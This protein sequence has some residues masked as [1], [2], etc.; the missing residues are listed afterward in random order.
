MCSRAAC[1]RFSVPLA[2]T[3]K[4]VCGSRRRPVVRRLRGRVD[5]E[6]DRAAVLGEQRVDAVGVADVELERAEA[7]D[8]GRELLGDVAR[9]RPRGRRSARACRSRAR[10]RRSRGS[11]KWRTRLGADQAAGAGDDGDAG[12][13]AVRASV[14]RCRRSRRRCPR[15]WC[16]GRAGA[17]SP[18]ART[19]PSSRTRSSGTSPGRGS[20]AEPDLE[21][22]PGE[23]AAERGRLQQREAARPPPPTLYGGAAPSASGARAARSM[24]S[25]R[26][27]TCSR[28]RTCLPVPPKPM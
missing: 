7:V 12:V 28:S 5:D 19:A 1:S 6:L 22:A 10:S 3:V 17:A 18:C 2:L 16:A 8:L 26:S 23:L 4:S 24:R 25:E 11:A 13:I 27:S 20:A 14:S 9:S 21:L 15:G